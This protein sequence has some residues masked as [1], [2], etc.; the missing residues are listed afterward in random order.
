MYSVKVTQ[1]GG[2]LGIALPQE[3]VEKLGIKD[4]QTLSLSKTPNGFELSA[5]DADF[6]EQ[7]R[8]AEKIMDRYR[9]TLR[10]LAK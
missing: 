5:S 4:G 9:E 7:M 3:V 6:E 8:A 1:T 2:S 10:K